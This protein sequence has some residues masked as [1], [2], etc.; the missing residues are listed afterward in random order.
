MGI[1]KVK[2]TV[3]T[4]SGIVLGPMEVKRLLRLGVRQLE[5]G[6]LDSQDGPSEYT[7]EAVFN[8]SEV[9][10]RVTSIPVEHLVDESLTDGGLPE[11]IVQALKDQA[12][13]DLGRVCTL[14]VNGLLDAGLG[15]NDVQL[16]KKVVTE[17]GFIL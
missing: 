14:G 7:Y 9:W 15:R 13:H 4:E 2:F 8:H 17:M 10:S 6:T 11:S 1:I 12:I 16:L 5:P 3:T